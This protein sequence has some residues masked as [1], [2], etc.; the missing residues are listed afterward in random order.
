M[1]TW[2]RADLCWQ[3]DQLYCG[4][5]A[6]LGIVPDARQPGGWRVVLPNGKLSDL[7]SRVQAQT[8]AEAIALVGLN[9]YAKQTA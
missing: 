2:S 8:E 1:R 5:V 9:A 3:G 6:L 4:K 7:A